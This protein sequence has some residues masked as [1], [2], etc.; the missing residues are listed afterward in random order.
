[1]K[2]FSTILNVLF[3]AGIVS[4]NAQNLYCVNNTWL[5]LDN[6][7][8]ADSAATLENDFKKSSKY[9]CRFAMPSS[10]N[11]A[12]K[13]ATVKDRTYRLVDDA[14][15]GIK[16]N[17]V[18][19]EVVVPCSSS[20]IEFDQTP[21][22][23]FMLPL[24]DGVVL[25]QRFDVK[26]GYRVTRYDEFGKVR[27][28]Q[29]FPHTIV[30]TKAGTEFKQPY[31]SYLAYTDRFVVFT[32]LSSHDIHK[33]II[34]DLKDGKAVPLESTVC[35]LIRDAADKGISG[36]LMRD[37]KTKT[38]SVTSQAGKWALKEPNLGK[39]MGETILND[40]VLVM[41]RYYKGSPGVSLAAF[42]AK[43]GKVLWVADVKKPTAAQNNV[44]LSMYKNS[45]LMEGNEANGNYLQA[46]DMATGK[47]T[48]SSI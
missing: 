10:I 43:T 18:A 48:Y 34:V 29:A 28:K 38:L 9:S 4:A 23:N 8:K 7:K 14:H 19:H 40:S 3:I 42:N 12:P 25:V 33:T 46:F 1:M 2:K 21:G 37:E 30:V 24:P 27:M 13:T 32:S 11:D 44:Y 45:I 5:N 31:L 36:Y 39:V 17:G 15:L 41:A 16:T 35:G 22:N 26:T 20:E 47:R 6:F